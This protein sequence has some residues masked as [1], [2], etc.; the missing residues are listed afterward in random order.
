MEP[1]TLCPHDVL[2]SMVWPEPAEQR[3]RCS[4]V[5]GQARVAFDEPPWEGMFLLGPAEEKVQS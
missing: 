2:L 1:L 3:G 4:G 5:E